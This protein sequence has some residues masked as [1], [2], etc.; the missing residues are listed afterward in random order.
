[1]RIEILNELNKDTIFAHVPSVNIENKV[2]MKVKSFRSKTVWYIL[3]NKGRA[4][5]CIIKDT[6]TIIRDVQ[7]W[8]FWES[9]CY[10]DKDF[11]P[12]DYDKL[13][14]KIGG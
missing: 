3:T 10:I 7:L 9:D 14:L 2:Y 8:E 4:V 6:A 1:M 13:M 12:I 11:K 5:S